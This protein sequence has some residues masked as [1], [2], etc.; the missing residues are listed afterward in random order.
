MGGRLSIAAMGLGLAQGAFEMAKTYASKRIQF[1]RP[2]GK[3]QVNTFK[4]ADMAGRVELVGK[5]VKQFHPGDLV[6]GISIFGAFAEYA[7][8]KEKYLVNKPA[9]V[10]F[11]EAATIPIAAITALQAL[12][13]KGQI[14][15]GQG[16]LYWKA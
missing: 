4:L 15:S 3:F 11:E 6:Y 1:G 12:R 10:S 8:V 5:N 13:D 16:Q 2:V 9:N 14:Q 7:C